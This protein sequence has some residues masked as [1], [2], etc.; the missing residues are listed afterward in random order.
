MTKK[1]A[2][3][4]ASRLFSIGILRVVLANVVQELC[5]ILADAQATYFVRRVNLQL[6]GQRLNFLDAEGVQA[7]LGHQQP[8]PETVKLSSRGARD[9][10]YPDFW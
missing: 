7:F 2:R 9:I 4:R 1:T 5:F 3:P 8:P 10:L 6:L